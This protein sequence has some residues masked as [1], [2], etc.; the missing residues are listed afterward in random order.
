MVYIGETERTIKE[1]FAE[2]KRDVRPQSEKPIHRHVVGHTA[3]DLQVVIQ[4]KLFQ[5]TTRYRVLRE[6]EWIRV[7][8]TAVPDGCDVKR[9][10]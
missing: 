2:H 9:N 8:G 5:E 6:E 3:A 4:R 7:L 1:R 10:L